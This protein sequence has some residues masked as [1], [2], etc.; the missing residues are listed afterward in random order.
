MKN[1]APSLQWNSVWP[2]AEKIVQP[3]RWCLSGHRARNGSPSDF[4]TP[5]E[6]TLAPNWYIDLMSRV[7]TALRRSCVVFLIVGVVGAI[8]G[9]SG[10]DDDSGSAAAQK[11]EQDAIAL[12]PDRE[13]TRLRA[14]SV[15][16]AFAEYWAALQFQAWPAA[17]GSYAPT[18]R[19]QLGGEAR[20]AETLKA[21]ASYFRTAKPRVL[22]STSDRGLTT[23]QYVIADS[24]GAE[25][26]RS[27]M[28]RRAGNQW[29]IVYDSFLDQA[30]ASYVQARTQA[31]IDPTADEPST[32]AQRAGQNAA[33][34]Q[35]RWLGGLLREGG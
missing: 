27:V 23:V 20:L 33:R 13:I 19:Q 15:E 26:P 22:R 24:Q 32:R 12:L 28:F 7:R 30:L 1:A 25:V 31:E 6:G 9:C 5:E 21:Q 2:F 3:R 11:P 34:L 18:L 29:E 14:G 10:D 17:I 16:R 4:Y 35:S 8:G